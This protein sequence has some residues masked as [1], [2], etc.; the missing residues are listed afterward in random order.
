MALDPGEKRVGVALSD[1]MG[2]TAQ[3]L[4]VLDRKPNGK[5]LEEIIGLIRK[6]EV[7]RIVIGLPRRTDG[8]L[9]PEAQ[10][11]QALAGWLKRETGVETETWVEWF[12]TVTAERMLIEADVRRDKRQAVRDKVAATIILQSYLDSK[13]SSLAEA[14]K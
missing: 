13:G 6:H 2:I 11:A 4:T 10:K 5:F 1:E 7:G 12:S 3:G 14:D 9:G 8:A